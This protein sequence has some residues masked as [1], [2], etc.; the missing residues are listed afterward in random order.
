MSYQNASG[1][2]AAM[3]LLPP[4]P[5]FPPPSGFGEP[6]PEQDGEYNPNLPVPG[7]TVEGG[8]LPERNKTRTTEPAGPNSL[9]FPDPNAPPANNGPILP[10]PKTGSDKPPAPPVLPNRKPDPPATLDRRSQLSLSGP[11]GTAIIS[12]PGEQKPV[13]IPPVDLV[14]PRPPFIPK[15]VERKP[16]QDPNDLRRADAEKKTSLRADPERARADADKAVN[17]RPPSRDAMQDLGERQETQR[18]AQDTEEYKRAEQEWN[19]EYFRLKSAYDQAL[20]TGNGPQAEAAAQALAAHEARKPQP[21][22]LMTGGLT[23]QELEESVNSTHNRF[24]DEDPES[25]DA[26]LEHFRT[27]YGE[28]WEDDFNGTYADLPPE[29]RMRAMQSDAARIK[30]G[31]S[32]LPTV[33]R[34]D[35]PDGFRSRG[36]GEARQIGAT[37]EESAV[38][39]TERRLPDADGNRVP[40]RPGMGSMTEVGGELRPAAPQSSIMG[41][42]KE[43]KITSEPPSLDGGDGPSITDWE[44][45]MIAVAVAYGV[46]VNQF[47]NRGDLVR[48][49]Q[50][51]LEDHERRSAKSDIKYNPQGRSYYTPNAA[52]KRDA[53]VAGLRSDFRDFINFYPTDPNFRPGLAPG[54][55]GYVDPQGHINTMQDALDAAMAAEPGSEEY[56]KAIAAFRAEKARVRRLRQAGTA[57]AA[58][59]QNLDR[60]MVQNMNNPNVAPA[61][62]RR[63]LEQAE[64]LEE[65]AKV[66]MQFGL[67]KEADQLL[68]RSNER[69]VADNKAGLLGLEAEKLKAETEAVRATAGAAQTRADADK[70]VL[71]GEVSDRSRQQAVNA[72]LDGE[73]TPEAAFALWKQHAQIQKGQEKMSDVEM[74]YSFAREIYQRTGGKIDNI[75]VQQALQAA[76]KSESVVMKF[77]GRSPEDSKKVFTDYVQQKTGID[78]TVSGRWYDNNAG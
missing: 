74:R 72:A 70:P 49:G 71:P 22:L 34:S 24:A 73:H 18:L 35:N 36:A 68:G 77:L 4:K 6:A 60:G 37:P 16:V 63:S 57:A 38:P 14:D 17:E 59:Q 2:R 39:L 29:E 55:E 7:A 11:D 51:L 23:P 19:A 58:R 5:Q 50:K 61:M 32:A 62:L 28:K 44:E 53:E 20:D 54:D 75:N 26:L 33:A 47:Q 15:P 42:L 67:F 45:G 76:L 66:M 13:P 65:Q 56:K 41:M 52:S 1:V 8:R 9:T 69:A 31:K 46:D 12:D 3:R 30:N 25:A 43:A 64:T 10:D 78:P 27:V 40:V 48:A 21:S